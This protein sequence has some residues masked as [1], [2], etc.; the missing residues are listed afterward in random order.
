MKRASLSAL[1]AALFMHSASWGLE[2]TFYRPAP[3]YQIPLEKEFKRLIS[4]RGRKEPTIAVL[5]AA[6]PPFAAIHGLGQVYNGEIVK[7]LLFFGIG[8][9]SFATW[10]TGLDKSTENAGLVVFM[11]SWIA[12]TIDAYRSARRINRQRSYPAIRPLLKPIPRQAN[13]YTWNRPP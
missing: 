9:L 1:C 11:G 12:S 13:A 10:S 8:Q 7:A 2:P 5:L 3:H 4:G 6:V